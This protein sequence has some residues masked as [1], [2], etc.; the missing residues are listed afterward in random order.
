MNTLSTFL[1]G[2]IPIKERELY[3]SFGVFI[4]CM[5]ECCCDPDVFEENHPST[6]TLLLM[7]LKYTTQ[8][9]SVYFNEIV[10]LIRRQE[11]FR[12]TPP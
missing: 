3:G 8:Y 4:V 10:F 2:L 5:D 11:S 12:A 6:R 1:L 7:R 9:K